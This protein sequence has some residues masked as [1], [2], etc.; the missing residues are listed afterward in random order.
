M[1]YVTVTLTMNRIVDS[2]SAISINALVFSGGEAWREDEP[3]ARESAIFQTLAQ[4]VPGPSSAE[5]NETSRSDGEQNVSAYVRVFE[6]AP[7]FSR[8]SVV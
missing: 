2:S 8:D 1:G 6:G 3:D 7:H 5:P 4:S